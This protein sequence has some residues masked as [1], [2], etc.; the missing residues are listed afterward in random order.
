MSTRESMAHRESGVLTLA[1][2]AA[3]A[4]PAYGPL[5]WPLLH[6]LT[7]LGSDVLAIT[8][9]HIAAVRIVQYYL[10]IPLSGLNP[11]EYHRFYIPFFAVVLYL[12]EGYKSPELRRPEQELERSCKALTVSFL[13]LVLFNFVVFRAEA[14]SRYLLLMWFALACFLLLALRFTLRT[15]Y[16]KLWKA[17]LCRWRAL[18]I[19][20]PAGLRGY[21]QLLAIQRHQGYDVAGILLDAAA[22]PLPAEMRALPVL[23]SLDDWEASLVG[24]GANLLI[25]AYPTAPDGEEWLRELVLRCKQLR[26]DVELYSSVLATANLNYEHDEFSGCFRFY[27][28]PEWSLAVQRVIKRGLDLVIGLIG[29]AV[30]LLLTP[31]IFV[32][33]NLEE[34]GPLF[35]RSAYLGQDG[36]IRYYLKF[37]TMHV[38]ADRILEQDAALRSRFREKQKL[39]DDPRVTRIGR[40]LR[41][42]SLDEFPQFF[43]ILKGDLTFVGPRT[44]REEE[45]VHYGPLLEKLL[46]VK[47][48]VTGF[49]QV[50]GRQTTT[51]AERVQMDM[52]YIDKWSIWLDLVIIAKTFWKVLKAEGAY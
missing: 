6:K 45:A 49:W 26:V 48:G 51:Y 22:E 21:Q 33:V 32:L 25:V 11:P 36:S 17:G 16:E 13:G 15:L 34:R 46:S 1:P 52:F 38:D 41:R 23:G 12:F 9:A 3:E 4:R 40:L 47:P 14:F 27:A 8:L 31:V 18:L 50:M 20:S 24:T 42:S 2:E 37:R 44:I 7:Y 35:Y 19:G 28:K 29:S 5:A 10:Q 30:T 43:S 39:I